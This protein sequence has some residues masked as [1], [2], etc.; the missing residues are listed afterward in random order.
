MIRISIL[1]VGSAVLVGVLAG[2]AQDQ[3]A[4]PYVGFKSDQALLASNESSRLAM[5]ARTRSSRAKR[6]RARSASSRGCRF[7]SG[8]A[9][10][11]STGAPGRLC[12]P[13]SKESGAALAE[14]IPVVEFID[15]AGQV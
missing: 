5:A 9:I 15:R 2:A 12:R 1:F 7:S 10:S 6:S 4:E 8:V 11:S 13:C 3:A 14:E